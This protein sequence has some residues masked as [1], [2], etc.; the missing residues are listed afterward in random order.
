MATKKDKKAAKPA[1]APVKEKKVMSAEEKA[2]LIKRPQGMC[3]M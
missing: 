2:V 3:C 1:A